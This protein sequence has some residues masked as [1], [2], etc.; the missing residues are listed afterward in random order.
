MV[1]YSEIAIVN[2]H[3]LSSLVMF[4]LDRDPFNGRFICGLDDIA[5]FV[6]ELYQGRNVNLHPFLKNGFN[7]SKILDYGTFCTHNYD[8]SKIK[9]F[10]SKIKEKF[11]KY[12]I[13]KSIWEQT[14]S[15]ES[16]E[17]MVH[18]AISLAVDTEGNKL[19]T[20]DECQDR[21]VQSAGRPI[22]TSKSFRRDDCL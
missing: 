15:F 11:E 14:Y 8:Y 3:K 6:S 7:N 20:K 5:Y 22:R 19:G 12:R 10:N 21:T 18:E 9:Q 1:S 17:Q 13:G 16:F 4:E 2:R